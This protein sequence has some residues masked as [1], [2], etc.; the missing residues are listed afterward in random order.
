MDAATTSAIVEETAERT[1][2]AVE[3]ANV[4]ATLKTREA[5]LA[6]LDEI[7]QAMA[8]AE[9]EGEILNRISERIATHLRLTHCT[10]LD[11]DSARGW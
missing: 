1:W 7:S 8:V 5:Q 9:P 2:A 3:R 11:V 10:F 6:F 4:E